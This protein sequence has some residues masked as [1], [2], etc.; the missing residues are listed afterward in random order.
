M[1]DICFINV[2][3][4]GVLNEEHFTT[5]TPV[6]VSENFQNESQYNNMFI[7]PSHAH[8]L[9]FDNEIFVV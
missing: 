2:W 8:L 9:L 5:T 7:F 3:N 1:Y 4:E 6:Y